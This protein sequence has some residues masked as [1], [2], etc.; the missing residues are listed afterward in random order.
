MNADELEDGVSISKLLGDN[1]KPG[2]TWDDFIILPGKIDFHY[3]E[4][5]LNSRLT[6]NYWLDLP[7][8]SS[9]M[10]TVT[11]WVMAD[12]M[13]KNGGAG[14]I[15]NN[16]SIQQQVEQV[17]S[18]LN[19][20][21]SLVGA[22]V[23]TRLEDRARIDALVKAGAR[24]LVIDSA[25]GHSTY[26]LETID[27]IKSKRYPVDVIA[28][29]VVT[30][31]QA[32]ALLE[33]GADG[34][35]VGMGPGSICTTQEVMAVGRAQATAVYRCAQIADKY[36]VPVIADGGIKSCGHIVRALAVGAGTV[37]VGRLLAGSD[38]AP[39]WG[40]DM[41]GERHKAYRGMA[42]EGAL[43]KGGDRRYGTTAGVIVPQ[44]VETRVESTGPVRNTLARL[45]LGLQQALQDIGIRSVAE[46]HYS[47]IRV[48]LRSPSA[49][50][51]GTPHILRG[52]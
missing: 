43:L 16:M 19:N 45:R 38:E 35:R 42:S 12:E 2:L 34:L 49:Q 31:K 15:H 40:H 7:I 30:A 4:V 18:A 1:A 29:N 46:F 3:G 44:G 51:E 47:D 14:I 50:I 25:Q 5:K 37:M 20:G 23:S 26:Q 52:S 8:V 22:A 32:K 6:R 27:Y 33:A 21:S 41:T 13:C 10:D 11:E 9:P 48:E 24:I 28:G 36:D 39:G 17:A